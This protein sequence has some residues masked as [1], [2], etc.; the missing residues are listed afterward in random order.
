MICPFCGGMLKVSDSR[1][2]GDTVVRR[3]QCLS[4]NKL[5]KTKEII[6]TDKEYRQVENDYLKELKSL[7]ENVEWADLTK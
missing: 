1:S 2:N 6:I 3:R 7:K 4:C 5:I